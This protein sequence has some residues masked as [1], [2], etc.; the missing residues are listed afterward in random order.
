MST[1]P[2]PPVAVAVTATLLAA[3]RG[4]LGAWAADNER[5]VLRA[6]ERAVPSRK[7]KTQRIL[8]PVGYA[9]GAMP[10]DEAIRWIADVASTIVDETLYVEDEDGNRRMAKDE[11]G[12]SVATHGLFT[13]YLTHVSGA[14]PATVDAPIHMA[15]IEGLRIHSGTQLDR[16]AWEAAYNAI[17]RRNAEAGGAPLPQ[18]KQPTIYRRDK[19]AA[20]G[21]ADGSKYAWDKATKKANLRLPYRREGATASEL[22]RA[23]GVPSA[24][25]RFYAGPGETY[26]SWIAVDPAYV[27]VIGEALREQYP[28]L[29]DAIQQ[30]SPA[31]VRE[32]N[33]LPA[34]AAPADTSDPRRGRVGG[35][36]GGAWTWTPDGR[37]VLLQ[38]KGDYHGI[39]GRAGLQ[40]GDYGLVRDES[41]GGDWALR[42]PLANVERFATRIKGAGMMVP[43]MDALMASLSAIEAVKPAAPVAPTAEAV[44]AAASLGDRGTLDGVQYVRMGAE[45]VRLL[46]PKGIRKK[47][48][49]AGIPFQWWVAV[50]AQDHVATPMERKRLDADAFDWWIVVETPSYLALSM[51]VQSTMPALSAAL[52]GWAG[53][54]VEADPEPT[55][56]AGK[57]RGEGYWTLRGDGMIVLYLSTA[58]GEWK[59]WAANAPGGKV[60][61]AK[62][63]EGRWFHF[64]RP[65]HAVGVGDAMR[66]F[67]PRLGAMLA[68]AYR[69]VPQAAPE[70]LDEA[71]P[72]QAHMAVAADYPDVTDS[73]ALQ[74]IADVQRALTQRLPLGRVPMPYQIIGSAFAKL[75]GYRCIIGDA[76]GLGKT[77]QALSCI[78]VDPEA[79]LPAV[80]VAPGSVT[81]KWGLEV[82]RWLPSVPVHILREGKTPLPARGWKGIV[83]VSWTLLAKFADPLVAWGARFVVGDEIHLVKS[84]EAIRTVALKKLASSIPHAMFLSGTPVLNRVSEFHSPLS[85]LHPDRWGTFSEFR[86]RYM[87]GEQKPWGMVWQGLKNA[88]ELQARLACVMVRRLKTQVAKWLPDKSR[89]IA[90]VD[91]KPDAMKQYRYIEEKFRQFLSANAAVLAEIMAEMFERLGMPVKDAEK[92]AKDEADK[93]VAKTLRAEKLVLVGYLRRELGRMKVA[94]AVEM[95]E[96]I[97]DAGEPVLLYAEHHDVVRA[98]ATA[99]GELKVGPDEAHPRIMT[100][101]G[102]DSAE[103]KF[104]K[105]NEFQDGKADVV[106]GTQAIREG[107]DLFRASNGIFVER[108]WVPLLE[109][110]AEDRMHRHGQ[111]NAVTVWY[112]TVKGTVDERIAALADEKRG[113]VDALLGSEDTK[114]EEVSE[115]AQDAL[116]A[117]L[118]GRRAVAPVQYRNENAGGIPMR[119]RERALPAAHRLHALLFSRSAWSMAAARHWCAMHGLLVLDADAIGPCYRVTVRDAGRFRTGTF[120]TVKLTD[121]IRAITAAPG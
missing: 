46:Y 106:I 1:A 89:I 96:T 20:S 10:Y 94:P 109:E 80:V 58:R 103:S 17:S 40:R 33:V 105:M 97:L 71:C 57:A 116:L 51:T 34:R 69:D 74:A 85:A 52:S 41:T 121:T 81:L 88:K 98:L 27:G 111:K 90:P 82:S 36:G 63:A 9:G 100:I 101:T 86:A 8:A 66:P 87:H 23:A 79:L 21:L 114:V 32:A 68:A 91:V 119:N 60:P 22:L 104:R 24:A 37:S 18:G 53:V 108:W 14:D 16:A 48:L 6:A 13:N 117:A 118:E 113:L 15:A 44:A 76:P 84:P 45:R 26:K 54:H 107:M 4:P 5:A 110:Q 120:R 83:V 47:E 112:P 3:T 12:A 64:F 78:A 70:G 28:A 102:L 72:V 39:A 43:L 67:W 11:W 62:D 73:T 99:I 50:R 56:E 92:K 61:F 42:I 65:E 19:S 29:A 35:A 38:F 31:W 93:S 2:T 55:H 30:V 49:M 95:A 115:N 59:S 75:A 77:I 25:Y 7:G